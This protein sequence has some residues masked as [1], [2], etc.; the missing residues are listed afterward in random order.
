MSNQPKPDIFAESHIIPDVFNNLQ[1]T[2][3]LNVYYNRHLLHNGQ[4]LSPFEVSDKPIIHFHPKKN[5]FYSLCMIDP[6]APSRSDPKLREWV[7][8]LVINISDDGKVEEGDEV[9]EYIGSK[10]PKRTGYHRY[11]FALFEQSE[12]IKY[13]EE[14]LSVSANDRGN[15]S[16]KDFMKKYHLNSPIGASFFI[17]RS[18]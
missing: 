11:I 6:D 8:W 2:Q 15:W 14:K 12:K 9:I 3:H 17:C 5:K 1:L 7:H 10:P 16:V 4:E 18:F 13:E